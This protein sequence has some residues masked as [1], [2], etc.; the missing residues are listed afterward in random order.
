MG[1][2]QGPIVLESQSLPKSLFARVRCTV[3]VSIYVCVM[4]L[5]ICVH[6]LHTLNIVGSWIHMFHLYLPKRTYISYISTSIS[7]Y[8]HIFPDIP[9]H[10]HLW[11]RWSE[12]LWRLALGLHVMQQEILNSVSLKAIRQG[13]TKR[14]SIYIYI[15]NYILLIFHI[16]YM[17]YYT[18]CII[19][20]VLYVKWIS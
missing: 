10:K 1:W 16:L 6:M 8:S 20:L 17:V 7:W 11:L 12:P 3:Y 5:H 19:Y 15:I 9:H 13:R 2:A 4:R 18:S 14:I